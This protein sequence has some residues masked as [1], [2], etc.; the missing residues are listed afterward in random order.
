MIE[1]FPLKNSKISSDEWDDFVDSS[2]NGTIFH[3][4]TFLSYHPKDRFEDAS[5][6]I[7]KDNK[8][9]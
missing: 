5:L 7:E 3:K 8:I 4:R 2:D 1:L 9:L 6:V